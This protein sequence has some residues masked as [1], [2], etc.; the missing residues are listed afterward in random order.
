MISSTVSRD[1]SQQ[2]KDQIL[3]ACHSFLVPVARFLLRGGISYLDFANVCKAAFVR[4]ARDEFGIR[5]RPTNSSRIAAMTGI[6]RKEVSRIREALDAYHD[7]AKRALSPLSD[8]LQ[9]WYTNGAYLDDEGKPLPL[10]LE[11]D[12]PSFTGLVRECA[13]DVP[14]GAVRTELIRYGAVVADSAGVLRAIRREVV[15]DS[16][17]MKLVSAVTFSLASLAQTIAHNSD[18]DRE[19]P[20]RV[21]RYVQSDPLSLEVREH[22]RPLIRERVE[23]FTREMDD[24]LA[25][26]GET[27]SETLTDKECRIGIGMYYFEDSETA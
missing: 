18:P 2:T 17:D 11:G 10:P 23:R 24:L 13:G 14:V 20:G 1:A 3:R 22:L 6:P 15:P 12:P 25:Q 7:D 9:H 19:D 16:F 27:T 8:V 4:V 21:E 26:Y 5:G